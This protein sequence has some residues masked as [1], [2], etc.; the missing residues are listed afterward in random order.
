MRSRVAA[1]LPLTSLKERPP[2]CHAR[3]LFGAVNGKSEA[4]IDGLKLA[5]DNRL[6]FCVQHSCYQNAS[7]TRSCEDGTLRSSSVATHPR[8]L[9]L[10]PS[11]KVVMIASRLRGFF[12]FHQLKKPLPSVLYQSVY[13]LFEGKRW[14]ETQEI[15][16]FVAGNIEIIAKI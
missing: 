1:L 4:S 13:R 5:K 6:A 8:I 15:F 11:P 2:A 12:V 14:F 3:R 16:E 10:D 7:Q 9:P